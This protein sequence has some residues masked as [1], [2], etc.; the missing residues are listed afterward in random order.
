MALKQRGGTS[1]GR[2][3]KCLRELIILASKK[4]KEHEDSRR[5]IGIHAYSLKYR[6]KLV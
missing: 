1:P 4:P 2:T 3:G 5:E 6:E